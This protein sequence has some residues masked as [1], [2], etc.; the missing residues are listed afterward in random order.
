MR[1]DPTYFGGRNA[2]EVMD[3]LHKLVTE[4]GPALL[5]NAS[6]GISRSRK[7]WKTPDHVKQRILLRYRQGHSAKKI[8]HDE[9][10]HETTTRR[11]IM[12]MLKN[13]TI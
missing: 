3:S 7:Y 2:T 8:A 5:R 13:E 12:E 9:G 6:A 11:I 10:V 4:K 1:I